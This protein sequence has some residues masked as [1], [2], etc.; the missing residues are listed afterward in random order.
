[1]QIVRPLI[2]ILALFLAG[3]GTIKRKTV[4]ELTPPGV[5]KTEMFLEDVKEYNLTNESFYINK[6][7]V[8]ASLNGFNQNLVISMKYK[9]PDSAMFIVKAKI[10]I[11]VARALIT[12][13]TV[14]INDR[15]NKR[16]IISG[17]EYFRRKYGLEPRLICM[18]FGDFL[19][20]PDLI[21]NEINCNKNLYQIDFLKDRN[22]YLMKFD[23][24]SKKLREASIE[25]I[26]GGKKIEFKFEEFVENN[27][28]KY[29]ELSTIF[30]SAEEIILKI[31]IDKIDTDWNGNIDFVA[32]KGYRRKILK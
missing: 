12:N 18:M 30:V 19:V 2:L 10:G 9:K 23:C 1:M 6:A 16:L 22:L 24:I 25:N 5:Y 3:C 13:D 7:D 20:K 14:I 11:E 27:K 17:A 31:S 26:T 28:K 8:Q 32:N 4:E 29:P 21:E 15:L